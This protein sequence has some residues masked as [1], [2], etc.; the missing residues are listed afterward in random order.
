MTKRI[1]Q[2]I[3]FWTIYY[4]ISLYNELYLSA[5]FSLNPEFSLFVQSALA[6]LL[7]LLVKLTVTYF[8]MYR[9]LPKWA[10][11]KNTIWFLVS[12]SATIIVGVFL[13]RLMMHFVIWPFVYDE[14]HPPLKPLSMIARFFYSMFDLLQITGVAVCIKL[15][16]LRLLSIR[17]EKSLILERSRAEVTHL[18]SQTNPHFLFNTLNSIYSLSRSKSEQTPDT[19]MRLSNILRFTLYDSDKKTISIGDELKIIRDYI[20]LQ[21]LRFG[22]RIDLKLSTVIDSEFT[23]IAPLLLL[24]LIENAY[25]HCS[26]NNAIIYFDLQLK[27]SVLVLKTSNTV[28]GDLINPSGSG[29]QNLKR[30][31]ELLYKQYTLNY[32]IKDTSFELELTI[33]LN[34]Y[35]GNELF[36]TR[37]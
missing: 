15:Y 12:V 14:V 36:D 29:L 16:K 7:L 35:A 28:S 17:K 8:I 23:Q 13:I 10:E 20:E 6:V 4:F 18:K 22:K 26:E 24:P 3:L 27:D 32:Y 30:Q 5:S 1:L 11:E 25:K 21:Q 19:I 33:N 2:H 31:L 34:T 9:L 37:G